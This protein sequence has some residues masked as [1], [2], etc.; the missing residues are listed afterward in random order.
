MHISTLTQYLDELLDV[1][2]FGD[3]SYNGL[4]VAGPEEIHKIATACSASLEAIDEAVE[5]GVDALIVHH[6]LF[7]KGADPRL[8]GNYFQRVQSLIE[9]KVNLLAYHLPLDAHMECGNNAVVSRLLGAE[10]IDYVKPGDKTSIAMRTKLKHSLGIKEVAAILS[11]FLDTKVSVLGDID[12]N[13]RLDDF[14][15]CTGSGASFLDD[16]KT[17]SFQALV[18]GDVHEQTYHM[19]QETGTVVFVVGH[20]ASEQYAIS[21]LGE[22][23]AQK[24]NLELHTTHYTYERDL[25]VFCVEDSNSL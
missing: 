25:K 10:H 3:P 5:N 16:D 23:L 17:P 11:H 4:Q 7:W 6:G 2:A 1:K 15:I 8:I 13:I 24:F 19:A 22:S 18:T 14:I 20:H 12:E 21:K 9:G